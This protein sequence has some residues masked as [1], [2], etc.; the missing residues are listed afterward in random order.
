MVRP[1]KLLAVEEAAS[2]LARQ[3]VS[4]IGTGAELLITACAGKAAVRSNAGDLPR[5]GTF[6]RRLAAVAPGTAPPE[7]LYLRPPDANANPQQRPRR[8]QRSFSID[9]VDG[10]AAGLLAALH[11]ECFDNPWGTAE[12]VRLMATPGTLA[13]IASDG[14]EPSAF[15]IA[16]QATDEAEILT[17]GTRPF[18]RRQGAA[19]ALV[20]SSQALLARKGANT[21][22]IEVARSNEPAQRL[23]RALGFIEAGI[24]TSYY[25]KPGGTSED[26]VIMRKDMA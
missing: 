5:A 6:I 25:E 3:P 15:L 18:A 2:C 11:A 14:Q 22:F 10:A 7:P 12:I 17:L 23:Y 24:R 1:P 13:L 16:R 19:R 4:V 20:A 21:L 8:R 26:A 9:Q